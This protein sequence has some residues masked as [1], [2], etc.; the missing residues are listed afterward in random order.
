[1]NSLE[2]GIV[3]GVGAVSGVGKS[4]PVSVFDGSGAGII[5]VGVALDMTGGDGDSLM[6]SGGVG[7]GG[8]S[9]DDVG[10]G[11]ARTL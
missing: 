9:D 1:M 5:S 6:T 8:E 10:R 2:V 11:M 4:V 7:I 3:S